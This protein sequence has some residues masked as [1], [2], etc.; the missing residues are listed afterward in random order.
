MRSTNSVRIP[1]GISQCLIGDPVRFNAGHKHS[2]LCTEQLGALF[3]LRPFCPEVAIGLGTPRKPIRLAGDPA[4]P[5]AVGTVDHTLDVTD[6]LQQYADDVSVLCEELCGFIFMQ[7]SPSC[8]MERVKVYEP[9]GHPAPATGQGIFAARLMQ[10]NPL[11]PV[12]EEG[13]LNDPVLRENF[14]NRVIVYSHW[15]QLLREELSPS[16]LLAF[17]ARHKYLLMAHQSPSYRK[18]GQMLANP[19][20]GAALRD[21]AAA[22]FAELMTALRRPASRR[23]HRN[24][25]QH[26][27]GH[28]KKVL[29]PPEKAELQQLSNHYRSG[30]VP[31]VVPVTLLQHHLL[32]H[33]DPYLLQQAYLQ[34]HPPELSL[35]NAI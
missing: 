17:H 3:E 33:P 31:L 2:R 18:M 22:Y 26:V 14:G 13:R 21:T 34:P 15:Q 9:N 32:R 4:A 8:G 20:R 10:T 25:L 1:V 27:A 6:A 35:R 11:L 5:R 29:N 19:G 12:E 24:V 7:K 28:F 23:G 30:I 16:R